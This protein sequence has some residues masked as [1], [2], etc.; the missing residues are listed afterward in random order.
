M[1]GETTAGD[2]PPPPPAPPPTDT[3]RDTAEHVTAPLTSSPAPPRPPID[4]ALVLAGRGDSRQRHLV[5]AAGRRLERD[6]GERF[7]AFAFRVAPIARHDIGE[8]RRE[9]SSELL[10]QAATIRDAEHQDFVLLV[11]PDELV[12]RYRA[13]ALAALSRPLDAAVLSTA[14]LVPDENAP[15]EAPEDAVVVD[16]VA[17]LMTHA[18]AHLAGLRSA[19]GRDRLLH[20]P[21]SPQDL[22]T[23]TRFAPEEIAAL[24]RAFAEIA[25]TRLE[26]SSRPPGSRWRFALRAAR[27]NRGEIA[28]AVLAARPWELPQRLSRLTTAAVS[29]LAVLLMTAESWDLGLSQSW[30]SV[31]AL[32]LVALGLTTS[33]VTHRQ[34]LLLVRH[35]HLS[36]QVVTTRL[37]A[38]AIVVGGLVTT[39]LGAFALALLAILTLFDAPLIA[40][41]AASHGL[42]ATGVGLETRAR[43][44][45][46]CASIALLIGALGASFEE[47]HHFRHVILV[48]EEL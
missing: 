7:P 10:R 31:L 2:V 4:I 28:R 26:E 21:A 41:W 13:F 43:M 11:T 46:F 18:L 5:L 20:R 22:D 36:E 33:F 16:R 27:I 39:W 38:L 15:G 29:T 1:A 6:L 48:D 9:E 44:A 37:T 17:T 12:A 8:F 47:Q 35:R 34:Q 42:D 19:A 14:R 3:P 25:D 40:S 30:R 24:E 23:M 32:A 45:A